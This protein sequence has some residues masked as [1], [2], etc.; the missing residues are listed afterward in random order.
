MPAFD[1]SPA[2][3]SSPT[4]PLSL[5]AA[6]DEFVVSH[7]GAPQ[8]P[9][10]GAK[11]ARLAVWQVR[12][13]MKLMADHMADPIDLGEVA[14]SCRVSRGYFIDA[15]N[16]STGLTPHQWLIRSRL[17]RAQEL[18][19]STNLPL[20]EIALACGFCDQSHFNRTF[21]RR[22]G[23]TPGRWRRTARRAT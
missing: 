2:L 13:A 6:H 10:K 15:F 23:E 5:N 9:S 22:T 18:L 3:R 1:R 21:A 11:T 12:K 20:A 14:R 17:H 19:G 8:R 7:L 16:A 4:S